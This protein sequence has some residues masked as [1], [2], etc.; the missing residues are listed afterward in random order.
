MDLNWESCIICLKQTKESLRCPK[1]SPSIFDPNLYNTFLKNI[2]AFKTL[3]C[4][5]VEI[6]FDIDS[7]TASALEE[8]NAKWHQ[9]C[10]LKFSNSKFNK[11]EERVSKRVYAET[12]DRPDT[13]D[14]VKR[15]WRAP[16]IAGKCIICNE[17]GGMLHKFST[18]EADKNLR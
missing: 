16:D 1:N 5:P 3:D 6:L 7:I 15:P 12:V 2:L 10:R 11:V 8:N 18:Y 4:L 17:A 9:S 13:S 14:P